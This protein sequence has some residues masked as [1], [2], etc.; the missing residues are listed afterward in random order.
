ME[1]VVWIVFWVVAVAVAIVRARSD[2]PVAMES[3][4][5]TC[6]NAVVTRGRAGKV[7]VACNFGGAMR[8]VK[9]AV[10]ECTGHLVE[11]S[12][13]KLVTIE[14]FARVKRKVY[15]EITIS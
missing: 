13:S 14:G 12:H 6:M 11:G 15:A 1:D 4:C 2:S 5:F 3:L 10:R 9:F 8:P 7:M